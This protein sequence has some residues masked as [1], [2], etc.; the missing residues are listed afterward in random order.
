MAE[1]TEVR[2][3]LKAV[4][5]ASAE[6]KKTEKS[7]TRLAASTEKSSRRTAAA[8]GVMTKGLIGLAA[9]FATVATAR[10]AI[11]TFAQFERGL[12]GVQKT[13][14]ITGSELEALGQTIQNLSK[15]LPIPTTQLLDI[16]Q[17]AGQ[18]GIEGSKDILLFTE[19]VARLG[20]ASD[21]AGN[22][23]A[24]ALARL[25][26][27]TGQSTSEVGT[28]AAV[29]VDLGN[30]FAATEREIVKMANEIARGTAI[31]G[32]SGE[33]AAALGAVAREMGI[34]FELA[35]SAIGRTFRTISE[36]LATGGP[37]GNILESIVGVPIEEFERIFRGNAARGFELFLRGLKR[38]IEEG[39]E[40]STVLDAINLSGDELNKTLP[41]MALQVDKLADAFER[42]QAQIAI[43]DALIKESNLAIETTI[44]KYQLMVNSLKSF[45]ITLVGS[46]EGQIKGVTGT[47]TTFINAL[48]IG[49]NRSIEITERA[50]EAAAESARQAEQ[51]QSRPVLGPFLNVTRF[52]VNGV[53]E[54]QRQALEAQGEARVAGLQL[55]QVFPPTSQLAEQVNLWQAIARFTKIA[56]DQA[57]GLARVDTFKE[58]EARR[59]SEQK[60]LEIF[61][62]R[63]EL[64]EKQNTE[65][66]RQV[67]AFNKALDRGRESQIKADQQRFDDRFA[68]VEQFL[69]NE[70]TATIALAE[71]R[72]DTLIGL[73]REQFESTL[74]DQQEFANQRLVIEAQFHEDLKTIA[75]AN[76]Q[77]SRSA[78]AGVQQGLIEFANQYSDSMENARRAT[79]RLA[80]TIQNSVGNA[81]ADVVLGVSSTKEAFRFLVDEVVRELV[82]LAVELTTVL[83]IRTAAAIGGAIFGGGPANTAQNRALNAASIAGRTAFGHGGITSGPQIALVGDN[84]GG[85][86]AII[87]LPSG[88]RVPVKVQEPAFPKELIEALASGAAAP[89]NATVVINANDTRTGAQF[90][91]ENADAIVAVLVQKIRTDVHTA[92]AIRSASWRF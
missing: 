60:A 85:R 18:L 51:R 75:E 56:R 80:N 44:S 35:G 92:N 20:T 12:I 36:I 10:A 69:A 48:D 37:Q 83:A 88:D 29:I 32:V 4:D 84:P 31:F 39:N 90:V 86:E 64:V 57:E 7:I 72:R 41:V 73:W 71:E 81:L 78:L 40:A 58:G 50:N 19:T 9:G 46:I 77:T 54:F 24:T 70:N 21:L 14:N 38:T 59:E 3:I 8:I 82:R 5:Q 11:V 26:A 74:I 66:V 87:P 76:A 42:M 15:R 30:N 65:G 23:A 79:L 27:V 45:T 17:A 55:S 34:R 47:L 67:E 53:D 89:I 68:I 22:E 6:I 91:I 63:A 2:I 49:L 16:A 25:L 61:Q 52:T 33:E 28:L 13:T 1:T 43:P 62:K